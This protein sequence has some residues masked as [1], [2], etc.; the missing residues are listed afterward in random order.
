M[1]K[2]SLIIL[3]S[4]ALLAAQEA[5]EQKYNY[6]IG[7]NNG[8][9]LTKLI[10]KN[11][12]L[13]VTLRGNVSHGSDSSKGYGW[14]DRTQRSVDE[15]AYVTFTLPVRHVFIKEKWVGLN[16]ALEPGLYVGYSKRKITMRNSDLAQV[17]KYVTVETTYQPFLN[18]K[19]EPIFIPTKRFEIIWSSSAGVYLVTTGIDNEF[20]SHNNNRHSWSVGFNFPS[21]F[22]LLSKIGIRYYF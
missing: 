21:S 22:D 10:R 15:N 17:G 3:L 12:F 4:V 9:E 1:N 6:T 2:L 5:V 18:V 7:Y 19:M 11:T 14:D 13:G 16:G 8:L 20:D